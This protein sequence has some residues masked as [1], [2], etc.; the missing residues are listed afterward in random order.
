MSITEDI[1]KNNI[2]GSVTVYDM[3]D[4][5]SILPITGLERLSLSLNTPGFPGYE[6]TEDKGTPFQIYKVD[7]IRRDKENDK[8][9]FYK[10][11][12]VLLKCITMKLL[13]YP[14]HIQVQ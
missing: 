2:T 14:E 5:R 13:P 8:G 3:Q 7:F 1:F 11:F 6:F 9:Q 10:I 12:S 4:V